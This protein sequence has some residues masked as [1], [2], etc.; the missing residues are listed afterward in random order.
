[1]P[2]S[3]FVKKLVLVAENQYDLYHSYSETDPQLCAQI[4]RY[5]QD[6]GLLFESCI[7]I[8]WSAVFVSWCIKQAGATALEFEFSA[9]HSD[10]V[11]RAIQN[12]NNSVGVFRGYSITDYRPQ[13]GDLI[14]YNRKGNQFDFTYASQNSNYESHSV[15]VTEISQ[16]ASGPHAQTIGGNESNSVRKSK[17]WLTQDGYIQQRSKFS[18]ISVIQDL[19]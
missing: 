9:A 7:T 11:Y 18:Y 1:M 13:V 19:K 12:K 2:F 14:Q 6:V 5:W 8:P 15:I 17:V 4:K 16:D 10:F 3:E